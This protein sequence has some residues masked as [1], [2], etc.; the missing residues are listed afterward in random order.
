MK[1][2]IAGVVG[3]IDGTHVNII[4]PAENKHLF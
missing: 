2:G 1:H 3:C 4:A